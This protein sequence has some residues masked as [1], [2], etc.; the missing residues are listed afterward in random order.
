VRAGKY[1]FDHDS[2]HDDTDFPVSISFNS[3]LW[4]RRSRSLA[5]PIRTPLTNTIG[6]VGHPVHIFKALRRRQSLK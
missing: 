6:K 2:V 5:P 4:I 3:P 1:G